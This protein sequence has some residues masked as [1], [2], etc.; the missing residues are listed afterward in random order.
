MLKKKVPALLPIL[1]AA[2]LALLAVGCATELTPQFS[3]QGRL[4]DQNGAP[5]SG[6]HTFTFV[7]YDASQDGT[8]IYTQTR[9][10]DVEDGLFDTAIGPTT[11]AALQGLE[12][13]D[14]S[15]PLWMEVTVGN[16]T[17]T[18][19][20]SPRQRLYGAPYAFTLMP[21]SVI[22]NTMSEDSH[23]AK[24]D[25][26][27]TM[28]NA[29][30]N[31]GDNAALP[32]LRVEG[33]RGIELTSP[34]SDNGSLYT[35]QN[36]SSSDL[37]VYSK[38]NV[39]FYID[40]DGDESG[41]FLVIGDQGSCRIDD[42]GDLSCTGTINASVQV[43]G[44]ERLMY[45]MDS[46]EVWSEDF[47]EAQ[48][49]D[50]SA[51]VTIDAQFADIV[52]LEDYHVFVTPLGDCQGLYV[53]NETPTSFE[54]HELGGG[55]SDVAFDYRIVAHPVNEEETRLEMAPSAVTDAEEGR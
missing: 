5:V 50:G 32:A 15:Q 33:E 11:A 47:G 21:G 14:L 38:D 16:G 18:E 10:I 4:T 41:S 7:L 26:V 2:I 25:A 54:V 36:E 12:P 29:H 39:Q 48:L 52:N 43:A 22:S 19:T 46:P 40:Q 8:A 44:E 49:E 17:V 34:T 53:A 31:P 6:D 28:N 30:A 35:D 51:V 20:L 13:E 45:T 24:F 23:G 55:T 42:Q 9:T 1:W 27:V 3:Y 37:F